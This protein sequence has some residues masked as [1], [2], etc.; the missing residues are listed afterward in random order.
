M[1][2]GVLGMAV[3]AIGNTGQAAADMG[4]ELLAG[5]NKLSDF[6]QH[7]TGLISKF[8]IIGGALGTLGQGMIELLDGQIDSFRNLSSTG[9]DFGGS[10]FEI[11]K[12]SSE[13]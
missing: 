5:G 7:A 4:M 10:M 2:K 9:V 11:M 12:Q 1:A 13:A 3:G 6:S 8:P